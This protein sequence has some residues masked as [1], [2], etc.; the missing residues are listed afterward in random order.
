MGPLVIIDGDSFAHRAYHGLPKTIRCQVGRGG[1]SI[2]G[3]ANFLPRPYEAEQP[4]AVLGVRQFQGGWI[5]PP[6]LSGQ[7]VG[8]L[9]PHWICS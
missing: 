4:R 9:D 2:I 7:R 3:F 6:S 8:Q 1:G 5:R